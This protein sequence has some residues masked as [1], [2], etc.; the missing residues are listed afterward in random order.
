MYHRRQRLTN[1]D[2]SQRT[3]YQ[4]CTCCSG[5]RSLP[6]RYNLFGTCCFSQS[7]LN[8]ACSRA[9]C[10]SLGSTAVNKAWHH[11]CSVSATCSR[12]LSA[13]RLAH[14][15]YQQPFVPLQHLD[16]PGPHE[17]E[18]ALH[19]SAHLR[20][21]CACSFGFPAPVHHQV[22]IRILHGPGQSYCSFTVSTLQA[23][24]YNAKHPVS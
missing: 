5:A 4:R 19:A 14:H 11:V 16:A 17:S 22:S 24:T 2:P 3:V 7:G 12:A 13:A 9:P 21:T 1:I 10:D 15:L 20:P 18:P 23:S 8:G 6:L